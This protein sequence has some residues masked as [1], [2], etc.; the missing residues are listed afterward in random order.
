[1]E[2]RQ[3]L[4]S[5]VDKLVRST[6]FSTIALST[7]GGAL[8]SLLHTFLPDGIGPIPIPNCVVYKLTFENGEYKVLGP[9][10]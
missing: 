1:M 8:R 5:Y 2:F 6:S 3:R 7:H 9:L 10:K 4:V